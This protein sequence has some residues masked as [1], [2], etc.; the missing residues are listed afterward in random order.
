MEEAIGK[1]LTV[2]HKL[3]HGRLSTRDIVRTQVAHR[4]LATCSD[5]G[6]HESPDMNYCQFLYNVEIFTLLLI[7][8]SISAQESLLHRPCLRASLVL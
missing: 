7:K 4:G 2:M 5:H 3:A 1:R 8:P 6:R